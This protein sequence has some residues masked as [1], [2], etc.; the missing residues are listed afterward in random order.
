M[1]YGL[2]IHSRKRKIAVNLLII[3]VVCHSEVIV[4]HSGPSVREAQSHCQMGARQWEF[5]D[6]IL[7]T[8]IFSRSGTHTSHI[9]P[10]L[11]IPNAEKKTW[12]EW[13]W[14]SSIHLYKPGSIFLDVKCMQMCFYDKLSR[15]TK[16]WMACHC[17]LLWL[18]RKTRHQLLRSC[19]TEHRNCRFVMV[20]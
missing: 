8:N 20:W 2:T 3:C 4:Q 11:T 1:P 9:M 14:L 16:R 10:I 6:N 18:L 13:Y 5:T 19:R 12:H 17:H 15:Y 7:T